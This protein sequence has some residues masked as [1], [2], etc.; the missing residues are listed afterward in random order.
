MFNKYKLL[1]ALAVFSLFGCGRQPMVFPLEGAS[2]ENR[3]EITLIKDGTLQLRGL[4]RNALDIHKIPNPFSDFVY[5]VKPGLHTLWGMNIPGGHP[6]AP[7]GLRCYVIA[8]VQTEP[9]V[10]YLLDEDRVNKLAIIKRQDT[11]VQI[12]AGPMVDQR[13]A[14]TEICNWQKPLVSDPK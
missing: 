1:L 7:D 3:A 10:T 5:G 12:A 13:A 6:L 2:V 4:D 11:G 9:G 14:F 8:D